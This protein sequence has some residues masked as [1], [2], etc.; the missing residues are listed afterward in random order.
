MLLHLSEKTR[1]L[2]DSAQ[3]VADNLN[4]LLEL[5]HNVIDRTVRRV[6]LGESVPATEKI[7]SI[8]EPHAR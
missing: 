6:I 3:S 7:V 2:I 1:R 5:N 4:Q 8:F